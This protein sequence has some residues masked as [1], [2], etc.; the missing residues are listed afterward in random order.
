[1]AESFEN[2]VKIATTSRS[3]DSFFCRGLKTF[4]FSF[5]KRTQRIT[6]FAIMRYMNLLLTLGGPVAEWLACWTQAQ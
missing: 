2:N 3:A 6:G 1:M 4:L 5:Y